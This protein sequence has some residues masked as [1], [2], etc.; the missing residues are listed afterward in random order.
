[1]SNM[2]IIVFYCEQYGQIQWCQKREDRAKHLF[3]VFLQKPLTVFS[4]ELLSQ[5]SCIINLWQGT[6]CA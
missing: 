2:D 5:L 1:M 6:K 4:F 3:L